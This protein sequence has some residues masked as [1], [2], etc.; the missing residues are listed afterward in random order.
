MQSLV[1]FSRVSIILVRTQCSPAPSQQSLSV[2]L[3]IRL[4]TEL[5]TT[6]VGVVRGVDV[7]F[8]QRL[9]HV[10]IHIQSRISEFS[11]YRDDHDLPVQQDRSIVI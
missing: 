11:C 1:K 8:T 4:A 5:F 3:H 10:L 9:I 7:V 6:E 2:H